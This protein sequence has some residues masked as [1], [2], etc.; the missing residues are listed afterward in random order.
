ML[1]SCETSS[2]PFISTRPPRTQHRGRLGQAP[3]L[4]RGLKEF[5]LAGLTDHGYPCLPHSPIHSCPLLDLMNLLTNP[6]VAHLIL[7]AK[8]NSSKGAAQAFLSPGQLSSAQQAQD[9][10]SRESQR[11]RLCPG[12]GPLDWVYPSHLWGPEDQVNPRPPGL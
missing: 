8:N 11:L 7:R 9:P 3:G 12:S 2:I 10:S 4:V 5:A 1:T 6:L